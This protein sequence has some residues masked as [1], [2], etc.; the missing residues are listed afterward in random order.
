MITFTQQTLVQEHAML[1]N[2]M[3]SGKCTHHSLKFLGIV[4]HVAYIPIS[5]HI[6][7]SIK[8]ALDT[9]LFSTVHRPTRRQLEAYRTKQIWVQP[10]RMAM[11]TTFENIRQLD[12]L[13]NVVH[14]VIQL[15]SCS[16]YGHHLIVVA[17][18]SAVNPSSRDLLSLHFT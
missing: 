10:K 3:R 17:D 5:P 11:S 8:D 16:I 15:P 6:C 1:F 12:H 18:A 14:N 13:T 2:T 9:L 4:G 7:C